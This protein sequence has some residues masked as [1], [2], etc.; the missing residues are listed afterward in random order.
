MEPS[1]EK[2]LP[3][4]PVKAWDSHVGRSEQ[5]MDRKTARR[6]YTEERALD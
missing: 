6:S 2:P 1:D 4:T 5:K 3:T